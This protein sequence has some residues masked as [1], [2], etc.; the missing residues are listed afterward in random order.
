MTPFIAP[1]RLG[2]VVLTEP[3]RVKRDAVIG[4]LSLPARPGLYRL[5]ITLTDADGVP[6]PADGPLVADQHV[7]VAAPLSAAYAAT[8]FLAAAAGSAFAL[9]VRVAN[10]GS[11][12]WAPAKPPNGAQTPRLVA[13]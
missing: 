5:S 2:E 9:P 12:R 4:R 6:L 8:P 7:R 1:E 13:R 3:A 10:T 11:V